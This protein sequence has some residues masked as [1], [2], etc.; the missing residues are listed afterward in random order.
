MSLQMWIVYSD[1]I[2]DVTLDPLKKLNCAFS[3]GHPNIYQ[4]SSAYDFQLWSTFVER[5]VH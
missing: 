1:K 5:P 2:D 4:R 3:S